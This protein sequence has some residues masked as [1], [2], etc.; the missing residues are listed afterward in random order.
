MSA[1]ISTNYNSISIKEPTDIRCIAHVLNIVTK[2]IITSFIK[3][4]TSVEDIK[5]YKNSEILFYL[6]E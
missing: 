2:D 6:T 1:F 3:A 5:K 4:T